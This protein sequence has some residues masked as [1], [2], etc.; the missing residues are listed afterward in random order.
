MKYY[1]IARPPSSGYYPKYKGNK[2]LSAISYDRQTDVFIRSAKGLKKIKAYG[3]VEY[4]KKI[5][6][7]DADAYEMIRQV[8]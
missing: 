2:V 8:E 5:S 4:E 1:L 7:L 3:Y 6:Q